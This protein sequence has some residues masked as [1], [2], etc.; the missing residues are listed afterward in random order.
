MG[1]EGLGFEFGVELN[2]DEPGVGGNLDHL[3]ETAVGREAGKDETGGFE[4]FAVAVV[5]F[6]A[7]AMAF[8]DRFGFIGLGGGGAGP[9]HT[10]PGAEAHAVA[11]ADGYILLFH[12][13][14]D[15]MGRGGLDLG[16]VGSCESADMPGHFDDGALET[17]ADAEEGDLV[18]SGMADSDDL[19]L[20]AALA[21]ATGHKDAIHL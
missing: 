8:G 11:W 5:D 14:D 13:A 6:V 19:A 10:G 1:Q 15:G 4:R 16:G 18:F 21:E 2:G 12:E 7:V 9:D 17:Q 3:D 20:G